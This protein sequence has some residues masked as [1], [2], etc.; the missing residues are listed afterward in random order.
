MAYYTWRHLDMK[1]FISHKIFSYERLRYH[2]DDIVRAIAEYCDKNDIKFEKC[3]SVSKMID[4][5]CCSL[6]HELNLLKNHV[7]S[8]KGLVTWNPETDIIVFAVWYTSAKPLEKYFNE[9]GFDL[10]DLTC[11]GVCYFIYKEF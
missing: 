3:H 11:D 7:K 9:A 4:L 2:E 8:K 1:M 10:A 6:A 5:D